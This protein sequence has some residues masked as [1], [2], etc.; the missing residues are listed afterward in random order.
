[1]FKQQAKISLFA[2]VT[3]GTTS[4]ILAV[5]GYGVWSIVYGNILSAVVAALLYWRASKWRPK[6]GFYFNDIKDMITFSYKIFIANL[7]D[8]F[9][10]NINNVIIGKYFTPT[11]VGLYQRASTFQKIPLQLSTESLQSVLFPTMSKIQNDEE[12]LRKSY[13]QSLQVSTFISFPLMLVL[14]LSADSLVKVLLPEPWWPLIQYLEILTIGGM[15][16]PMH[17]ILTNIIVVKGLGGLFLKLEIIKKIMIV[18]GIAI[19]FNWGVY[20]I[21]VSSVVVVYINMLI[22]AFVGGKLVSLSIKEI[23]LDQLSM[24]GISLIVAVIDYFI[25]MQMQSGLAKIAVILVSYVLFYIGFSH[26]FN[27]QAYREIKIIVQR[28]I[29]KRK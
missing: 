11:D 15:V 3:S 8:V 12:R 6:F 23:L 21:V 1:M 20:G 13:K 26:L 2:L 10:M 16:Y 19:G 27:I 17:G 25:V 28:I 9:F 14:A 5:Q 18:I 29:L 24:F 22:N 7:L 4:I